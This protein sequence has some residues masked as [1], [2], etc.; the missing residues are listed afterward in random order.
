M[1]AHILPFLI[2]VIGS[3]NEEMKAKLTAIQAKALAVGS[4]EAL[5]DSQKKKM[6]NALNT[7]RETM[8]KVGSTNSKAWRLDIVNTCKNIR[9]EVCDDNLY[10]ATST[11]N[12]IIDG[13]SRITMQC[14]FIF[15][16]SGHEGETK[17]QPRD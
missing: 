6:V 1:I 17:Q 9:H 3:T 8:L 4:Y 12:A 2:I 10:M 14:L 15:C 13:Q 16:D 7:H 11:Y 5:S